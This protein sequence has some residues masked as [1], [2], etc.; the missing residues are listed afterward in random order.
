L[1]IWSKIVFINELDC[2]TKIIV[3]NYINDVRRFV[4]EFK[5]QVEEEIHK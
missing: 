3:E 1:I 2:L 5:K 4:I